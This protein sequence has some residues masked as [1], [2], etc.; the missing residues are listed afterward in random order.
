MG[1]QE[2]SIPQNKKSNGRSR[3]ETWLGKDQVVKLRQKKER[4]EWWKQG[5]VA[6]EE[7]IHDIWTGRN[8][9]RKVSVH[10]ELEEGQEK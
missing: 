7:H 3:K 8:E 6:W 2:L 10:R 4:C 5:R 9:L 1:A